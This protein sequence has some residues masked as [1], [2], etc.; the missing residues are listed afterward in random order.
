MAGAITGAAFDGMLQARDAV[1]M[2][3]ITNPRLFTFVGGN[4]GAWQ[5]TARKTMI[6]EPLPD[7]EAVGHCF[8]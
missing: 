6:G 3:T 2:Q 4:S 1:A 5:V 7:G 8:R